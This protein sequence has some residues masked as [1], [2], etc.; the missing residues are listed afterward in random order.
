MG[1]SWIYSIRQCLNFRTILVGWHLTA[2]AD[3]IVGWPHETGI[4]IEHHCASE[5]GKDAK[6]KKKRSKDARERVA[7]PSLLRSQHLHRHSP[8]FSSSCTNR[9]IIVNYSIS[10]LS[11]FSSLCR[12]SS[13]LRICIRQPCPTSLS[14]RVMIP[15]WFMGFRLRRCRRWPRP[16]LRQRR[17]HTVSPSSRT[18]AISHVSSIQCRSN[19][20]SQTHHEMTSCRIVA[21]ITAN[22]L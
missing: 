19:G 1:L 13:S 15:P 20:K 18:I 21:T 2:Y 3:E 6:Q 17:E 7:K 4:G 5:S 12:L 16:A 9:T 10:F 11:S 22:T 14:I 8:I